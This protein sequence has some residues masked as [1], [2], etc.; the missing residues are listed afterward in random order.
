MEEVQ[1]YSAMQT[2]E[3]KKTYIKT[4]LGKLVVKALNPFNDEPIE[5]IL[6]GNPHKYEETSI[7]DLW[8]DKQVV[9]FERMNQSLI[10]SGW[11]SETSREDI[12]VKKRELKSSN[13]TDK[14]KKEL[15]NQ[16]YSSFRGFVNRVTDLDFLFSLREI[17]KEID[18]LPSYIKAIE[19]RIDT[20][21]MV[22][23]LDDVETVEEY[24]EERKEMK[25]KKEEPKPKG[26][27][28]RPKKNKEK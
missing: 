6:H 11:L 16:S 14:E 1:I 26:K 23:S 7:I 12:E 8:S 9:Y 4:Q 25:R 2:G 5:V 24:E 21:S 22:R 17:G 13:Y 19:G 20:L 27:P 15:F 18:A 3:P 28:G 10:E